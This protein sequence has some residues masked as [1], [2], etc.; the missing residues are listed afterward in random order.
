MA[1]RLKM[2][3][4]FQSRMVERGVQIEHVR[5]AINKPDS[6]ETREDGSVVVTKEL[7]DG[8]VIE[9]VYSKEGFRDS[10]DYLMITAYYK[11]L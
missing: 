7:P 9:A 4:H 3:T 2:T 1:I 5:Q 11:T 10:H 6:T 8:R